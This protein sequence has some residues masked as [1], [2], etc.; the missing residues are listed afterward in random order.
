MTNNCTMRVVLD[1]EELLENW[2]VQMMQGRAIGKRNPSHYFSKKVR[3]TSKKSRVP[4]SEKDRLEN[5][6]AERIQEFVP[7]GNVFGRSPGCQ[8]FEVRGD[9]AVIAIVEI[10]S[11]GQV[12]HDAVQRGEERP[13]QRESRIQEK[14]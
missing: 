8:K 3:W 12:G 5:K 7:S 10:C 9:N 13:A 14:H 1:L 6:Q 2:S 4:H 11:L